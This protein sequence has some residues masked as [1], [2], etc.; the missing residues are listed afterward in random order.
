V[1]IAAVLLSALMAVAAWARWPTESL[2]PNLHA[3]RVVVSKAARTLDLVRGGETLKRYHIALGRHPEGAKHRQGDGRTPEGIFKLDYLNGGSSFHKALHI[4]YPSPTDRAQAAKAGVDPGG[5]VMVHGIMNGL[6]W[7]GRLHR[8]VDWTDGC[9]AVTNAEIDEIVRAV[10][11][12][13]TIEI[14]P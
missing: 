8:T 7:L 4:S 2:P 3:D 11:V 1:K 9:I 10:P 6:G 14:H 5:L 13:T 12:G